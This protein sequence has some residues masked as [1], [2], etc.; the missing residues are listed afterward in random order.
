MQF[1]VRE[2]A[3]G[4]P[5]GSAITVFER[6]RELGNADQESFWVLGMN[7][8]N[9]EIL[10]ECLFKG[11]MVI[12]TVDVR[13]VFKRLLMAGCVSFIVIHN[14][15]AGDVKPSVADEKITQ[16]LKEGADI[17]GLYFLDHIIIGESYYSFQES[18][19]L[20]HIAH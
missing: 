11:G 17:L 15:P 5:I 2:K 13:I 19:L 1:T 8:G 16:R 18:G 3:S 9:Q 10:N 12:T 7:A 20:Y 4:T 14:H 6:F